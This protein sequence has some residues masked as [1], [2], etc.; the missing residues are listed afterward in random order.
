MS[1]YKLWDP[2]IGVKW[3]YL[4]LVKRDSSHLFVVPSDRLKTLP[5]FDLPVYTIPN[6]LPMLSCFYVSPCSFKEL[7]EVVY[8]IEFSLRNVC[9]KD[10]HNPLHWTAKTK[11]RRNHTSTNNDA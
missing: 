1:Q 10:C 11:A 4:R 6:H 3:Q 9:G 2:K 8:G 5:Y 7:M